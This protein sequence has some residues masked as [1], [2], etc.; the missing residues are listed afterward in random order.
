[1]SAAPSAGPLTSLSARNMVEE[2]FGLAV[3]V[4][5]SHVTPPPRCHSIFFIFFKEK[6]M[7]KIKKI[8]RQLSFWWRV[9]VGIRW[10]RVYYPL[11]WRLVG[12]A[13]Q[14]V[15]FWR[16]CGC[17]AQFRPRAALRRLALVQFVRVGLVAALLVFGPWLLALLLL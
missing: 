4:E 12:Q 6:V 10:E 16:A 3:L 13:R 7:K 17:P 11:R 1:M 5:N 2:S 15:R 14:S 8:E 9:W